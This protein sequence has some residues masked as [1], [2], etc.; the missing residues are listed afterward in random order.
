MK[1]LA[2][3]LLTTALAGCASN[4]YRQFYQAHATAPAAS[5]AVL[6]AGADRPRLQRVA[7]DQYADTV[8]KYRSQ[9]YALLGTAAFNGREEKPERALAQAKEIGATRVVLSSRYTG[10][11]TDVMSVPMLTSDVAYTQGVAT[12]NG[13][14]VPYSGSHSVHGTV[15]VPMAVQVQ[16]YDHVAAFLAKLREVPKSG[17]ALAGLTA[18]QRKAYERNSGAVVEVVYEDSPAFR[19]DVL[20]GDLVTAVDGRAVRTPE[21]AQ[22]ALAAAQQRGGNARLQILRDGRARELSLAF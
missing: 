14:A 22:A 19:A 1:A 4:G 11:R 21:E 12:V 9:G 15:I 8:Q 16:L 3:L 6:L 2:F 18:A 10:T 7:A 5:A 17:L 20:E 13:R